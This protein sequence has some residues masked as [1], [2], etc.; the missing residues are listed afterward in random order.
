MTECYMPRT[1]L[2]SAFVIIEIL[3]HKLLG[4]PINQQVFM[5][6]ML[7]EIFVT[8]RDGII[9]CYVTLMHIEMVWIP[10]TT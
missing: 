10:K 6:S 1:S 9:F 4:I 8:Q 3:I 2:I 7:A 5:F